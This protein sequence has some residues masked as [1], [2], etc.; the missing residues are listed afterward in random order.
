[1]KCAFNLFITKIQTMHTLKSFYKILFSAV[2][3]LLLHSSMQAQNINGKVVEWDESMKMEMP[4]PGANVHILGTDTAT[5]T[6]ANGKFSI[7]ASGSS[8]A[9][10]VTS[11]VGY[12][13]DTTTVT[14]SSAIKIILQKSVQLKEINVTGKQD[15]L[16][17]PKSVRS[18]RRK[19]PKKKY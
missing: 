18:I 10:L 3:L 6:D 1:V 2:C 17:S 9:R 15:A 14:T 4:L 19:Y 16:A 12:Q 11:F 7:A 8:H 5:F 13:N